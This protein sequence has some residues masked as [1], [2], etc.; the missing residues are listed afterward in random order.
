MRLVYCLALSAVS[1]LAQSNMGRI[2]GSV[3]DA[4]GALVPGAQIQVV[5]EGTG[6]S[7]EFKSLEN[8]EYEVA[9][10]VA[11]SYR[12]EAGRD[13]FKRFVRPGVVL[14]A[15]RS[16]RV[17]VT[18]EIGALAETVTV[19]AS[20]PLVETESPSVSSSLG[21]DLQSKSAVTTGARPWEA[22][23]TLP[24]IQSGPSDFVFSIAGSRGA[25]S[26]FHI[27]GIAA[28]TGG[29]PLGSGSMTS[30]G[31]REMRVQAV[32]NSAEYSQP[33]IFQQVSKSGTNE[34]HGDV[35]YYHTNS[36][37]N[38]RS[39]FSPTKASSRRHNFGA[40][41]GAPL[42]I[43]KLY[44]GRN[45]TFLMLAY[46]ATR[47]P[48]GTY[49]NASVPTPAMRAG[50]F[51]GIKA[52]TDPAN[53]QPFPGARIP[54]SRINGVS[55][56]L[57][58]RF[59]TLP[60]FGDLNVLAPNN[61][62]YLFINAT[63]FNNVDARVDQQIGNKNTLYARV[64]WIQFNNV[65]LEGKMPTIGRRTQLRNLRSGVLS[66][67]HLFSPLLINEFRLG[68]HRS[69]NPYH[70]PQLGQEVLTA[71]GIQGVNNVPDAYGI[72][73]VNI[74]GLQPLTQIEQ[75]VSIE[76]NE[77]ISNALTRIGGRHTLKMGFDLRR[78]NPNG[79]SVPIG[80]YGTFNFTN[81]FTGHAYSDF[82]LGVPQQSQLTFPA[83]PDRR[84][85]WES[86]F[87]FND[88]F[89]VNAR[90]TL[91]FGLRYEYQTPT[92]QG[93]DTLYNF[94]PGA[95]SLLLV[96]ERSRQYVSRLF[97]PAIPITVADG[98]R[99]PTGA[100]WRADRNNFA[101]RV[102]VAW[103]PT[104]SSDF[105]VRSGYGVF[106]D[107]I[108]MG[109]AGG[110]STGPFTPGAEIFTNRITNGAALF[111]FPRPFPDSAAGPSTSA[112]NVSAIL[113]G[114][115]SPYV[116]QWNLSV[117]KAIAGVGYRVSYIGSKGTQL[118]YQRQANRP[119][120]STT[121]F[122][123][124]L[125]PY[126]LYGD[127]T[128][129]LQGGNNNYH[130]LQTE[131][132]RRQGSLVFNFGYTWSNLIADVADNGMDNGAIIE[133]F[134]S[135]SAERAR[136]AY[137]MRHRFVGNAIWQVPVGRGR[138]WLGTAPGLVNQVL[139]GWESVWTV[140]LRSGDWFTPSFTGLDPSNTNQIG[141]RP[142]RIA[143]GNIANGT[144]ERWFDAAAF[145]LPPA[146]AGRFGNC[147]RNILEGPPMKVV[148][149]GLNKYFSLESLRPGAK[150]G[151][152]MAAKNLFNHPN[153]N[154][155]P[156]NISAPAAVGRITGVDSGLELGGARSIQMRLRVSW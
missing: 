123:Q 112:P 62:R 4:T 72:P 71:M 150:V 27:D 104:G 128:Q 40:W 31:T 49:S 117:E 81:A 111:Q 149:L 151:F 140:I 78:Q 22:L 68:F 1:L 144:V 7:R 137:S 134:N 154:D 63:H 148:H 28:P 103:R 20:V 39:F 118:F 156:A 115:R 142:D 8:G 50:D 100:L 90:V 94:D 13:G 85:Q 10:L 12:V 21:F 45:R 129:V 51:T 114:A 30:Q 26:E 76:Q 141:G 23:V 108:G 66:D 73:V 122:A 83:P 107:R 5:N 147:G 55:Q 87:F 2:V 54:A 152:E 139:G 91:Q 133:N 48:G 14:D 99:F 126:P 84:R 43:P 35:F 67:T 132:T 98:S 32:N 109:L 93:L 131:A 95:G 138:K 11:G 47:S 136:E 59:Y 64:G 92:V 52:I 70:G 121:R 127:I 130:A 80:T 37:L 143:D 110:F 42:V 3:K 89:K 60:N 88:D 15:G 56:R 77:Q 25:Q 105:A 18:L 6:V 34:L 106:Y 113:P 36:A 38:A 57:Q 82:L 41:L 24:T 86:G 102:G 29:S 33:G 97:N 155:P 53:G 46:E 96:S 75:A 145:A 153:F 135:R 79:E 74:T 61:Y 125:R 119:A 58:D 16:V 146:N 44:N 69:R 120:P 101:P 19:D 116:Q 124:A 65:T 9:S 17:D